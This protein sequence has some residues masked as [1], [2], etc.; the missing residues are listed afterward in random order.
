MAYKLKRKIF[1]LDK[2][3]KYAV[4]E[5]DTLRATTHTRKGALR[6]MKEGREL[7]KIGEA[8]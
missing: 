7:V 2:K 6:Y 1:M 4:F 8:N 5:G 3:D